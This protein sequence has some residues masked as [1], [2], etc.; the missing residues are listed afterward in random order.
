MFYSLTLGGGH[1]SVYIYK[2]SLTSTLSCVLHFI[3]YM[4]YLKN[5]VPLKYLMSV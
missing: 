4:L 2:N 3:A 5:K 1:V